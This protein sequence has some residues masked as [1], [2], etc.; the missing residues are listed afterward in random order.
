MEQPELK[1]SDYQLIKTPFAFLDETGLLNSERDRFFS[2]GM[3]K[4]LKPYKILNEVEKIRHRNNYTEE[5]KW[6]RLF[7][8]NL[9]IYKDFLGILFDV[10]NSEKEI[11]FCMMIVDKK[12]RYFKKH[13]NNDP[14]KAY[15]DFSIQLLKGNIAINEV[16]SVI[17]DESPV[18]T[19]STYETNVKE[20]I[21]REFNRLAMH[22]ICKVDSKGNDLLQIVD[23][24]VGAI[25]Y[26]L[27]AHH[28]LAGQSDS[29]GIRCKYALL[30]FIKNKMGIKSFVKGA[31]NTFYNIKVFE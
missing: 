2:L 3:V 25:T 7:P 16:L 1:L 4:C 22:G 11:F 24:L 14:F 31:R 29:I 10:L 26:D 28:K 9:Q 19:G 21:N 30:D 17:A 6:T 12:G 18:P 27:K 23:L 8:N 5:A 20:S 13:Y 15:E